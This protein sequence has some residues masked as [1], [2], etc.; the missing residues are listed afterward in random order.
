MQL[1]MKQWALRGLGA[2]GVIGGLVFLG[3][4]AASASTGSG[5][6]GNG[7]GPLSG[8]GTS[9]SATAPITVCG[10]SVTVA[11]GQ[12]SGTCVHQPV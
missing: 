1:S 7:S 10:N 8:N 5:G 12:S 6:S 4:T 11:S 3:A 2:A 9:V